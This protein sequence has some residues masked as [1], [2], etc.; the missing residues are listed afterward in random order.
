MIREFRN[1]HDVWIVPLQHEDE[2]LP[3][4]AATVPQDG[5]RSGGQRLRLSLF[6]DRVSD[7]KPIDEIVGGEWTDTEQLTEATNDWKGRDRGESA[8]LECHQTAC[9]SC[10]DIELILSWV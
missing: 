2:Q 5:R 10:R 6:S 9:E 4:V 7:S 1:K 8:V 3:I